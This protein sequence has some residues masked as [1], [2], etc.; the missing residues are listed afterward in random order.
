MEK[1]YVGRVDNL[2]TSYYTYAYYALTA[3]PIVSWR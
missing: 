3:T 1:A 2:D